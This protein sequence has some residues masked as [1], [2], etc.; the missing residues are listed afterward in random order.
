MKPLVPAALAVIALSAAIPAAKESTMEPSLLADSL[1]VVCLGK[2]TTAPRKALQQPY[3]ERL[4]ARIL[5]EGIPARIHNAGKGGSHAAT[6]ADNAF[7]RIAHG[8]D[9][10]RYDVLSQQPDWLIVAFGINDSW[11]DKGRGTPS[12]ISLDRFQQCLSSFVKSIDSIG[13]RTII[14]GPNPAG[15]CYAGFHA[16]RLERYRRASR[17]V[18]R[19]TG[20][21]WL[22]IS[23]VFR[24]E[25]KYRR[26]PLESLLLDGMHPNDQGHALMAEK[27]L[28]AMV[29]QRKASHE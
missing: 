24:R 7:H 18:A 5:N 13:G 21:R 29:S 14:L 19:R 9:R 3:P 26:Q 2:S 28:D 16:R 11:Q 1:V 25:F 22:D 6:L 27:L 10:F 4:A 17:K 15:I 23:S 12:R 20:A 8:T